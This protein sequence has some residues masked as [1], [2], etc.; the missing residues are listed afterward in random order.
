[1]SFARALGRGLVKQAA[2]EELLKHL[3]P[4][5]IG[6][7]GAAVLGDKE[8]WL[9]NALLGAAVGG[10]GSYGLEQAGGLDGL[11]GMLGL[12]GAAESTPEVPGGDT[13]TAAAPAAAG[14]KPF[15][16]YLLGSVL[17]YGLGWGSGHVIGGAAGGRA[18]ERRFAPWLSKPS[19]VAGLELPGRRA[20]L[21][22]L[23]ARGK[24]RGAGIG[25]LLGFYL[26]GPSGA[27]GG[28]SAEG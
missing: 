11:K 3:L 15:P 28:Y 13:E 23:K 26:G 16:K 1:M 4:A 9:R 22:Q 2:G 12:G 18:V 19:T 5:L 24:A 6:G 27:A 20:K 17:G 10:G 8:N 25:G 21:K 14:S 7:G